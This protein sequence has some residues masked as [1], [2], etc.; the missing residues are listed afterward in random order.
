MAPS[1]STE[2]TRGLLRRLGG[3][4]LRYFDHRFEEVKEEARRTAQ[5]E[6][7]LEEVI[8]RLDAVQH[9]VATSARELDV[10]GALSL[11]ESVR[12]LSTS[13][14]RRL[15]RFLA[16]LARG[17]LA[18][19]DPSAP[20][21]PDTVRFLNWILSFDGPI[22]DRGLLVNHPLTVL[23][24]GDGPRLFEVNERI[25][26][27]PFVLGVAARLPAGATVVDIGSAESTVALSLATWGHGVTALEPRG[28]PFDHPLLTNAAQPLEQWQPDC[29][30][31]LVVALSVV[32]HLGLGA[33][34]GGPG[35]TPADTRADLAA[36]ARLRT[37][38]GDG[39]RVALTVPTGPASRDDFQRVYDRDGLDELVGGWTVHA[40][41]HFERTTPTTWERV[42]AP[43][44]GGRGVALFELG[45]GCG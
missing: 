27:V 11:V 5:A 12:G 13:V 22:A 34:V 42:A 30:V 10:I 6:Q 3:P 8:R 9:L 41:A 15:D 38:L 26:E 45:P 21:S 43:P 35:S 33:Y 39:G 20:W 14:D 2:H 40:E 7:A 37:W 17:A 44:A 32:E 19:R 28:Y 24:D 36:L 31:D 25:V 18:A 1:D 4:V 29:P 16:D 23:F